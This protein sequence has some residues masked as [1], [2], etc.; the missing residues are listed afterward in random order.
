MHCIFCDQKGL[1][2][3]DMKGPPVTISGLGIA[4]MNC[5][6]EDMIRHRVFKGLRLADL[7]E[8]ELEELNDLVRAELNHKRQ[9]NVEVELF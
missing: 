3:T 9:V 6:T 1:S 7:V 5:A 8:D 2:D 4:H